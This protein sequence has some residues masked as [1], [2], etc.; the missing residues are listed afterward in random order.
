LFPHTAGGL[1]IALTYAVDVLDG[2][3]D[4]QHA[5]ASANILGVRHWLRALA[6]QMPDWTPNGP[7][8]PD[9]DAA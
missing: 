1:E 6:K 5:E 9:E 3:Y 4:A 8:K 2:H 7:A